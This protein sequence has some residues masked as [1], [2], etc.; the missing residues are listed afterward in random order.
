[1]VNRRSLV[2]AAALA[3]FVLHRSAMAQAWP[4]RP[5]R[6]VIPF[7]AGMAVIAQYRFAWFVN[8]KFNHRNCALINCG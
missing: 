2:G 7:P 6:M 8:R 5:M 3:P 1:M 4:D